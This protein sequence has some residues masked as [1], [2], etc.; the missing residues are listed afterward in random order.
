MKR[1]T[2]TMLVGL[3]GEYRNRPWKVPEGDFRGLPLKP[4]EV[5]DGVASSIYTDTVFA[6]SQRMEVTI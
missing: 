6:G 1:Y 5:F 3:N 2:E 4:N